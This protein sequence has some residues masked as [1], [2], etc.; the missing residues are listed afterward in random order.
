MLTLSNKLKPTTVKAT[1]K[2]TQAP[3]TVKPVVSTKKATIAHTTQKPAA[4]T[5]KKRLAEIDEELEKELLEVLQN[6][7]HQSHQQKAA[8]DEVSVFGS[9]TSNDDNLS[10]L[11]RMLQEAGYGD[12][13][14]R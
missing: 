1:V 6:E 4:T 8:E 12:R 14:R 10:L 7:G 5:H 2:A 13:R 11:E 9:K 3:T